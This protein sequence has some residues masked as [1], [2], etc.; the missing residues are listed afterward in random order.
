MSGRLKNLCSFCGYAAFLLVSL[1]LAPPALGDGP[2]IAFHDA[3]GA[4]AVT[5]FSAPDPLVAGPADLSLLVESAADGSPASVRSAGGQ[6]SLPGHAPV[7]FLLAAA[8]GA[9]P[10]LLH[11]TVPLAS[12]GDYALALEVGGVQFRG[13]LPVAANHDRRTAVL[14]T[15][16]LPLLSVALFLL[17]QQGKQ[18]SR[19][20]G[21]ARR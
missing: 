17:N 3:E 16:L 19:R 11:A 2:H 21:S 20:P 7:R 9:S 12:P 14:W 13:T 1:R 6:L 4:Y 10:G 5:L 15:V 18:Q 8:A